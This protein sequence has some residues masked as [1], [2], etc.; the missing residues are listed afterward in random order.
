MRLSVRHSTL[1]QFDAA[2]RYITQSHRLTPV[3]TGCQTV[4]DW[5]VSADGALF[6]ASFTDGAG[7]RITTMTIQGPVDR[8]TVVVEGT[9]ETVCGDGILRGQREIISP[10]V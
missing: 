2:M 7:D 6:G 10:L 1:Y 5:T 9:V 4:T 8:V 3:T